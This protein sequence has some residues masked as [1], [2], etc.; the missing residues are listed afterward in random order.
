MR[1]LMSDDLL[2]N[3]NANN[4]SWHRQF[5]T[6]EQLQVANERFAQ[7]HTNAIISNE[8]VKKLD[9]KKN[10]DGKLRAD[11]LPVDALREVIKILGYGANKYGDNNWKHGL[12][13][14]RIIA[15]LLRHMFEIMD[16]KLVDDESQLMHSAHVACNALFLVHYQLNGMVNDETTT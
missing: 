14:K 15:A 9:A 12:E 16:G 10:D 11:L 13:Q 7:L 4:M 5:S 6:P 2:N 1:I 8:V 3:K